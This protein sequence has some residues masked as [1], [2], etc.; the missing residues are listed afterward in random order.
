MIMLLGAREAQ[1]RSTPTRVAAR[2]YGSL[3][4][5]AAQL[6]QKIRP[7]GQVRLGSY[8]DIRAMLAT[9]QAA[10]WTRL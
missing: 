10:G 8:E 3:D 6:G 1:R 2:W 4:G 7:V 5:S 9:I